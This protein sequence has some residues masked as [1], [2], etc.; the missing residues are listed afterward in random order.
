ME[1]FHREVMRWMQ[2]ESEANTSFVRDAYRK[3][4]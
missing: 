1:R 4:K 3:M 2:Y